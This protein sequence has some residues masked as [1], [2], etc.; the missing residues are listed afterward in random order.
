MIDAYQLRDFLLEEDREAK[1]GVIEGDNVKVT[2][3]MLDFTGIDDLVVQQL[4]ILKTDAKVKVDPDL[5]IA[6]YKDLPIE[7]VE[8]NE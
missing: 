2:E 8:G 4:E 3:S 5:L 7:T 6:L 1:Q